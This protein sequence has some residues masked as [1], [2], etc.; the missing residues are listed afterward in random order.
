M[1]C[2][3]F[4]KS[5]NLSESRFSHQKVGMGVELP[6]PG[7]TRREGRRVPPR[8]CIHEVF[9]VIRVLSMR[10]APFCPVF[11][12]CI[13]SSVKWAQRSSRII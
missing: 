10:Q 5:L 4:G 7:E 3:A 8:A 6:C 9:M 13:T 11:F 2:V 12:L 1:T